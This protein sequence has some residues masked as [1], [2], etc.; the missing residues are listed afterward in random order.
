MIPSNRGDARMFD[1]SVSW[2]RIGVL[3]NKN[4]P[5]TNGVHIGALVS[6]SDNASFWNGEKVENWFQRKKWFVTGLEGLKATLGKD[7]S[8]KYK[9][10]RPI[11][12]NFLTVI[13]SCENL[14]NEGE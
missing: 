13:K 6:I 14:N 10:P 8:G 3:P 2:K 11:S 4:G 12:T 5:T 9:L 7:E 1:R